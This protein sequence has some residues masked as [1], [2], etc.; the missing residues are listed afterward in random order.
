MPE[1]NKQTEKSSIPRDTLPKK[2][3]VEE[4]EEAG[5]E[6]SNPDREVIRTEG[7]TSRSTKSSSRN[8]FPD[9]ERQQKLS[10]TKFSPLFSFLF[11][12]SQAEAEADGCRWCIQQE[13]LKVFAIEFVSGARASNSWLQVTRVQVYFGPIQ[14]EKYS[15]RPRW[16]VPS[17]C[18]CCL[19]TCQPAVVAAGG[20]KMRA[21]HH[22]FCGRH[23]ACMRSS[24]RHKVASRKSF[25]FLASLLE[26]A[27]PETESPVIKKVFQR[28]NLRDTSRVSAS[29][30]GRRAR[31]H[32]SCLPQGDTLM[33]HSDAIRQ[34]FQITPESSNFLS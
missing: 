15:S 26:T 2:T 31:F 13:P 34:R 6:S 8:Y 7:P 29:T 23:L 12:S 22:L 27:R 1:Q 25:F 9:E 19:P 3:L 33:I 16:C 14:R 24:L 30:L 32:L 18:I 28:T 5:G 17:Q 21:R 10:L 11:A 20:S 4:E